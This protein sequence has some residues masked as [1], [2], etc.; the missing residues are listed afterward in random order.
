VSTRR[1]VIGKRGDGTFGIFVSR[2]GFDSFNTADANLLFNISSKVSALILLT[3]VASTQTISL[4]LSQSPLA[5]VTSLNGLS[6]L[7]GYSGTGGPARPSPFLLLIPD[8]S[9]GFIITRTPVSSATINGNGASLTIS[10][11]APTTVAIYSKP[12]T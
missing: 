2:D 4:G 6:S 12:F 11:S 3:T 9:G 1:V 5:L 10:C 7:P 8:G